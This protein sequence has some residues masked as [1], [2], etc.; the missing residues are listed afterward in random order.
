[1]RHD[2][3]HVALEVLLAIGVVLL[4][5]ALLVLTL[6]TWVERTSVG[7]VAAREAARAVVTAEDPS[8]AFADADRLVR[9]IGAN[10]GLPSDAVSVCFSVHHAGVAPP[11]VCGGPRPPGRTDA[12]TAH[13]EVHIPAAAL[14]GLPVEVP[15]AQRRFVHSERVDAYRSW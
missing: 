11:R 7:R 2:A 13:V 9:Q 12:V 10:H 15:A 14:P 1:M 4:P 3:G 5:V 8:S 6:P